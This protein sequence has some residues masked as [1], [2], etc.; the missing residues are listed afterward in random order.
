MTQG[1]NP[2]ATL[3]LAVAGSAGPLLSMA[4]KDRIAALK[5]PQAPE[6]RLGFLLGGRDGRLLLVTVL[7]LLSQPALALAAVTIAS[8]VSAVLRVAL[9]RRGFAE[10]A[11]SPTT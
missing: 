10:S 6:R 8:L 9:V 2:S 5:L 11:S 3:G 1:L 7:A 4:T